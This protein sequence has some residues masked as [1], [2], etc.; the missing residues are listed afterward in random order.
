MTMA[1]A[2]FAADADDVAESAMKKALATNATT[3][4]WDRRTDRRLMNKRL[5]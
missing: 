2:L 5:Q 3:D 1:A 4:H